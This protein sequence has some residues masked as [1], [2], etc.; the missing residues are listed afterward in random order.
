MGLENYLKCNVVIDG[1]TVVSGG[2]L[3]IEADGYV[4]IDKLDVNV[5]GTLE[6]H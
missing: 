4:I 3:N 5:G 2:H 6:I 1:L